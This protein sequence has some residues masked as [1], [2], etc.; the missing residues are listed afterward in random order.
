MVGTTLVAT[1]TTTLKRLCLQPL[2]PLA[3]HSKTRVGLTILAQPDCVVW[4]ERVTKGSKT[5]TKGTPIKCVGVNEWNAQTQKLETFYT[6]GVTTNLL[7]LGV[8]A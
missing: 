7:A 2:M 4:T 5:P 1:K 6:S 3:R 8:H